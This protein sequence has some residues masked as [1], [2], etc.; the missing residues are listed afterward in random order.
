LL[1]VGMVI[2]NIVLSNPDGSLYP[3]GFGIFNQIGFRAVMFLPCFF[4]TGRV[5]PRRFEQLICGTFVLSVLVGIAS[6]LGQP[7]LYG[8]NTLFIPAL[9]PLIHVLDPVAVFLNNGAI[10]CAAF[11]I[12]LRYRAA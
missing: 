10:L 2:G 3:I 4:P 1:I 7:A 9:V 11:S 6:I 8:P 5:Y 12:V